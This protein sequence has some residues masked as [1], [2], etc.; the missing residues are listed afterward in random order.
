LTIL[1]TNKV[2]KFKAYM[3]K[4]DFQDTISIIIV[5]SDT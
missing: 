5:L 1:Y 4:G 2:I 3:I